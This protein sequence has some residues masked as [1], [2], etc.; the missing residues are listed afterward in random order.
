M[1]KKNRFQPQQILLLSAFIGLSLLIAI[2]AIIFLTPPALSAPLAQKVLPFVK[3]IPTQ[4]TEIEK[5]ARDA[6]SAQ[7][8]TVAL[9][10]TLLPHSETPIEVTVIDDDYE[11]Q[12]VTTQKNVGQVLSELNIPTE[13]TDIV[14]PNPDDSLA[15]NTKIFI[16]R[17]KTVALK[18]KD[19]QEEV[20]TQAETVEDFLEEEKITL[21]DNHVIEPAAETLLPKNPK[22]IDVKITEVT[23]KNEKNKISLPFKTVYQD[24]DSIYKGET[25]I[26]QNGQ[27]G[28]KTEIYH[29]TFEDGAEVSRTLV[30]SKITQEPV[31]KIIGQGTKEKPKKVITGG[32]ATYYWGP[33]KAASTTIPR[34][35]LVKVINPQNGRSVTVRIDDTGGFSWPTVIDL[36]DDLFSQLSPLSAGV[37]P[38]TIEYL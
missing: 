11:I 5:Y 1:R 2:P 20:K 10:A 38:V 37:I 13:A 24:D 34:G 14:T 33:T 36:R 3:N 9:S 31:N 8:E 22:K 7:T 16:N 30:D 32:Q 25:R 26:I 27:E 19:R 35:A 15:P 21:A 28:E 6:D 18:T 23:E 4:E 29:L 17:A 12:T